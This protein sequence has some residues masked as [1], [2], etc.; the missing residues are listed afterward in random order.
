MCMFED[1]VRSFWDTPDLPL[2]ALAMVFS[3]EDDLWDILC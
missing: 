3:D 1:P 2:L